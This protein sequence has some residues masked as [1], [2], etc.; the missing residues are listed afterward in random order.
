MT[1]SRGFVRRPHARVAW[2]SLGAATAVLV[3]LIAFVVA[4]SAALSSSSGSGSQRLTPSV[5]TAGPG[6]PTLARGPVSATLGAADPAYLIRASTPS[7]AV[8]RAD[9]VA[10]RMRTRFTRSGVTIAAGETRVRL[11]LLAIAAGASPRKLAS[12]QP[13]A[14]ANRVDYRR[15]GLTEWYANGPL[16]L[17]QGFTVQRAAAPG[18]SDSLT[19]S[20]ALSGNLHASST[21]ATGQIL[22]SH[23]GGAPVLR[24]GALSAYDASGRAL[25]S[26]LALHGGR[27]L[28]AVNTAHAR[29]PLT[30]DPLVEQ[31]ERPAPSDEN[32][33]GQFGYSVALSADG[34]TALVGAPGDDGFAGAAW[35]F[36]RAGSVW[37]Q[38]G[39]KLSINEQT[40]AEEEAR[41]EKE[42]NECGFGRSVALSADGNTALIGAPRANAARGAAWVFTRSGTTWS[43]FGEKLTGDT[44]AKGNASF[45]RSVALSGDGDTALVGAPRED[46]SR[47][48]A[49]AFARLGAGFVA[50]GSELTGE[51]EIGAAYFGRSLALSFDGTTALVGGPGD[52]AYSGAAWVFAHSGAGFAPE[53]GKLTAGAEEVGSGRFGFSVALSSDGDT[54]LVGARSDDE[55]AGAAWMLARSGSSWVAQGAKLTGAGELEAAQ[56]GY[57]VALSA[58]ATTA[59]VGAPH[60]SASVGAAWT[61]ALS[62]AQWAQQQEMNANAPEEGKALFGA[63]LALA[64]DGGTALIGAPHAARRL[65]GAWSYLGPVAE[66]ESPTPPETPT[67]DTPPG[68]TP[69]TG[70]SG[71]GST[72]PTPRSGVLGSTASALPPPHLGV[73]GNVIRLSGIVR[74]RLPGSRVFTLLTE[75]AQIPFGSL[76]DATHGRVSVTTE[77][78]GGGT[79]TMIFYEG[80]FKL[81][82]RHDGLVVSILAGGSFA[83]CRAKGARSG[84]AQTSATHKRP[85]R[86]LWAEGH[87]SYSTKGNYATGAVLGTRWLT[88]DLCDGTLIRVL[89]DKVAVT[90][91]VTHKRLTVRAGH[92]YFAKAPHRRQK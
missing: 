41:C 38:Q 21:P 70:S 19:L 90:N 64:A 66:P 83:S 31:A 51:E 29:F 32:G 81:T 27:V 44:E 67:D 50:E 89:T 40:D 35:V 1:P 22:L 71:T 73:N 54:A 75:G 85:V 34:T 79:Q 84:A 46:S 74:V 88:E 60:D 15:E 26:Q 78:A 17:E 61:F 2:Q 13:S 87:G 69:E 37:T 86:K 30:I 36:T 28:I 77:A 39:P 33:H 7:A 5:S 58:D 10:Q 6:L 52:D 63:G 82:Q 16:G 24:Y 12:V 3:S 59:L 11:R 91:L 49:W 9:G 23:A 68:P 76:V 55:D 8:L 65:G 43:Q 92:S 80:E 53:G 45:G 56:F 72:G 18:P 48:G 62:G 20:L 47:G 57:S 25:P 14:T 4:F 42:V